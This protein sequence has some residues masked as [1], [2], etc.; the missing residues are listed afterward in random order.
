VREAPEACNRIR[1]RELSTP[2]P[3]E[4][5]LLNRLIRPPQ[6]R[7]PEVWFALAFYKIGIDDLSDL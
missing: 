5:K 3:R 4:A 7:L 1:R 6:D 2:L